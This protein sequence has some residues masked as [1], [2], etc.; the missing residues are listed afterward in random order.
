[1]HPEL[2]VRRPGVLNT[3]MEDHKAALQGWFDTLDSH[4]YRLYLITGRDDFAKA[5]PLIRRLREETAAVDGTSLDQAQGLQELGEQ[6]RHLML[7][8]VDERETPAQAGYDLQE[9]INV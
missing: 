3:K 8:L 4:L 6:L 5:L 9:Q 1:M 7:T 2:A